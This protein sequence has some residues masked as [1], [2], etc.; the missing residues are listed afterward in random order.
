MLNPERQRATFHSS[1]SS[2]IPV[3]TQLA[4]ILFAAIA[5]AIIVSQAFI[6]RSTARGMRHGGTVTR[7]ALEW[8]YAIVPALA[9]VA[10]LYFS[11]QAMHPAAVQIQGVVPQIG[12]DS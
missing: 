3:A 12:M 5:L 10:L 7:P 4:D 6:L 2:V 11:W 1:L 8:T 9:L